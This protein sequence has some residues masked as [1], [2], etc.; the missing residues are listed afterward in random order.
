MRHRKFHEGEDVR[1]G[2]QAQDRR[3]I[4]RVCRIEGLLRPMEGEH[5]YTVRTASGMSTIVLESTLRKIVVRWEDCV[6]QPRREAR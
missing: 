4:G 1:V 6:W 3:M 5:R 2:P